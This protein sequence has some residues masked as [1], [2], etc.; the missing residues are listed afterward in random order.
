MAIERAMIQSHAGLC[1]HQP[2]SQQVATN[3][4][5]TNGET[6]VSNTVKKKRTIA[7]D[8]THDMFEFLRHIGVV[9]EKKPNRICVP[10]GSSDQDKFILL[11]E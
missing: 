8:Q 11:Q 3:A 6:S 2:V 1:L 4:A 10:K 7:M 9:F 5:D